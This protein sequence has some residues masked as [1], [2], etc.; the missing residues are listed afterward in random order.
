MTVYDTV[1]EFLKNVSDQSDFT[2]YTDGACSGNPGP[3][4]WGAIIKT[5]N[6]E[7]SLS[8]GESHT[9]NNRM[10]MLAAIEGLKSLPKGSNVNLYTDSQYVKNGTETWVH[11]WKRNGWKTSAGGAVKN[12]DCWQ[13]LDALMQTHNVQWHWVKG[14]SGDLYNERVDALA[15]SGIIAQEMAC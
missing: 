14:H 7:V 3:G 9:T 1:E 15:K 2:L 6:S 11:N 13:A 5:E 12:Q 4:G 8:G 10:E